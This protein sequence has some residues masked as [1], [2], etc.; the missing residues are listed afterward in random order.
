MPSVLK[1]TGVC[2]RL[3]NPRVNITGKRDMSDFAGVS[4]YNSLI[5]TYK[6]L[7]LELVYSAANFS[8]EACTY[9]C[10]GSCCSGEIFCVF[11]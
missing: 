11:V 5:C 7:F 9:L 10:D 4:L 8:V 3:D 6:I 2:A 1:A